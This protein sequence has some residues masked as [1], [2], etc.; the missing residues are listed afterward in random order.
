MTSLYPYQNENKVEV[1]IDEAGRGCLFG[2]VYIAGVILPHNIVELCEEEGIVIKD[3]KKLSKKAIL[4]G[5]EFIERC[6][7]DYKVIYKEHDFI[8]KVN[9]LRATMIGMHEV[10]D[11]LQILP[12]KILVDGDRFLKYHDKNGFE[13]E[14]EC[15]VEGDNTYM[16]IAAASILAKSYKE[17]YIEKLVEDEPDL[18]K[19]GLREN[20]GYGTKS[21]LEAII[22]NGISPYHRRT[23]GICKN[24]V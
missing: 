1:G 21:H 7:L 15:V 12:D 3:S 11:G 13:I 19:Y 5:R 24:Y 18:A 9:I 6:A 10:V 17:E 2:R 22:I 23:F 4:R 16:S 14:H 20:S 8:D